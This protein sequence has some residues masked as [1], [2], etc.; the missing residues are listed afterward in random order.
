MDIDDFKASTDNLITELERI[1]HSDEVPDDSD[2]GEIMKRLDRVKYVVKSIVTKKKV[3]RVIEPETQRKITE[4]KHFA[5]CYECKTR[6][7][8]EQHRHITYNHMCMLC[9]NINM[10]KRDAKSA[11][12]GKIAVVTGARIKIGFETAVSLL[13]NGATVIATSRFVDDALTRYS[14]IPEYEEFKDRLFLY[15]LNMLNESN[16]KEFV[17][18]VK[19]TFGRVDYL[20]NNAAQTIRRPRE[21]YRIEVEKYD[22]IESPQ[23]VHR[24]PQ[25][26]QMLLMSDTGRD[27]CLEDGTQNGKQEDDDTDNEAGNEQAIITLQQKL[28]KIFPPDKRDEFGQQIDLRTVNTWMLDLPDIDIKEVV[29]VFIINAIAPFILC[30]QFAGVMGYRT[31]KKSTKDMSWIINVTSMEGVFNWKSKPSRHVH[32]NMAKAA[33]NMMTRTC[34]QQYI[35]LGIVMCAVDTGWNNPQQPQSYDRATPID[36]KDG[37]TRILDPIYRRLKRH[38]IVYKDFKIIE[39]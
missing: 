4:N 34:G 6:I 39:F 22:T 37:S 3:I 16:I 1:L 35:D 30:Q 33:L 7:R 11:E 18:Y 26:I 24:N 21:F 8:S 15:Q 29:E 12:T 25:E 5:Y 17:A 36:C 31:E 2:I 13:R 23:I 32:T 14:E 28:D 38:S 20:I 9:G 19:E 27:L 10:F